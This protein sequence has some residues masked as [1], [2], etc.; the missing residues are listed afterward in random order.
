MK[1]IALRKVSGATEMQV[2]EVLCS[3][4]VKWI[5][6]AFLIALPVGGYFTLQWIKQFVY[7]Q[8]MTV[9]TYIGVG[10]FVFLV[11]MLTVVWQTWRAA[12]RNPVETLK[13]E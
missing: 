7:Q 5:L 12:V 11:G 1:E 2:M 13:S 10:V 8:H 4:F 3:R 6:I 9:W